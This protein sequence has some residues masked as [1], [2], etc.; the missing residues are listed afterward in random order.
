[1]AIKL[2]FGL[3]SGTKIEYN[4]KLKKLLSIFI[5]YINKQQGKKIF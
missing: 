1:M 3:S 5:I 4:H 2:F